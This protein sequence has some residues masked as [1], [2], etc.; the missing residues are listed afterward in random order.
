MYLFNPSDI[1]HLTNPPGLEDLTSVMNRHHEDERQRPP[2]TH[3]SRPTPHEVKTE[4]RF[5][6]ESDQGEDVE[7]DTE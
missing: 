2:E 3:P 7:C 5:D 4:Q 6:L 1:L